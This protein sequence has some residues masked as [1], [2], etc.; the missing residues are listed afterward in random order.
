MNHNQ[1]NDELERQARRQLDQ[2]ADA[3]PA[4]VVEALDAARQQAVQVAGQ[5]ERNRFVSWRMLG[6]QALAASVVVV[7]LLVAVN[8]QPDAAISADSAQSAV[9]IAL[10]NED[11]ELL[12]EELEFYWWLA[13][14]AASG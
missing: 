3:L 10:T 7:A 12:E 13:G 4:K 1:S 9:E 5:A 6:A 11:F 2:A 14:E 8:W